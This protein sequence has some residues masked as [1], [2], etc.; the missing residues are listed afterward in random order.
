[1]HFEL[2]DVLLLFRG[3]ERIAVTCSGTLAI[4]LGYRLFRIVAEGEASA[5][6]EYGK[7]NFKMQKVA[8]GIFFAL[9]GA[10]ILIYSLVSTARLDVGL[11]AS[12]A[13][14]AAA[15][16]SVER[17]VPIDEP[18]VQPQSAAK[19]KTLA[20]IASTKPNGLRKEAKASSAPL[21]DQATLSLEYMGGSAPPAPNGA[22]AQQELIALSAFL[23][24]SQHGRV[25]IP[26]DMEA[27]MNTYVSFLG[28]LQ[29]RLIDESFGNG[30]SEKFRNYQVLGP[31][32]KGMHWT[33]RDVTHF[34]TLE[35]IKGL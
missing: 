19:A 21:P 27:D 29:A 18:H 8:P 30:T 25:N 3:V 20:S 31:D 23:D 17:E 1:M 32:A 2:A 22:E 11:P 15:E 4:Y 34:K 14:T 5:E 9:F 28:R 24:L 35:T 26:P 16:S 10:A 7:F 12:P 13:Q 6:A 33:E